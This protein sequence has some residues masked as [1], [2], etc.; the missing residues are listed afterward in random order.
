MKLIKLFTLLTAVFFG[1]NST[2]WAE[3]FNL[4]YSSNYLMPAYIEFKND[5]KNYSVQA[6]L[7]CRYTILYLAPKAMKKSAI[8]FIKLSRYTQR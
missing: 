8:S 4:K 3:H 2:A 7:T 6:K 1:A 5:G